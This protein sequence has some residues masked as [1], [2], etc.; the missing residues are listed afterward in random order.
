MKKRDR[1]IIKNE[2]RLREP[3]DT[4][5]YDNIHITGIP[6]NKEREWDKEFI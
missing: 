1:K 6:E 5:K 2:N 4:I 3:S